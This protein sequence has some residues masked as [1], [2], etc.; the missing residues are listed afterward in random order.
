[1][2]KLFIFI[3][4]FGTQKPW[5]KFETISAAQVLCQPKLSLAAR[6]ILL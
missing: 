4:L 5:F 2:F 1:M 6:S 3:F